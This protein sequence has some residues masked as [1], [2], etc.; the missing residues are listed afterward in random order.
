MA[1]CSA[2]LW[3]AY[4]MSTYWAHA[5]YMGDEGA[6]LTQTLWSHHRWYMG[7]GTDSG[8]QHYTSDPFRPWPQI[9]ITACHGR[10]AHMIQW[11]FRYLSC[12]H[13]P[14]HV[15]LLTDGR[16]PRVLGIFYDNL[17]N[18]AG[19]I[20]EPDLHHIWCGWRLKCD[21]AE[22]GKLLSVQRGSGRNADVFQIKATLCIRFLTLKPNH[23]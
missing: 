17:S 21:E 7:G 6:R 18:H 15:L 2:A 23:F 13:G 8:R 19:P 22:E 16:V 3:H 20:V 9:L 1:T 5:I 10:A 4:C 12:L 14:Q 11:Y